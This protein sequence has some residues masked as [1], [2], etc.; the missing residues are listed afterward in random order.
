MAQAGAAGQAHPHAHAGA[1]SA[2][3]TTAASPAAAATLARPAPPAARSGAHRALAGHLQVGRDRLQVERLADEA[4]Q[5][6]HQLGRVHRAAGHHLVGRRHGEAHLFLRAQQDHV[7]QCRLHRVADAAPALGGGFRQRVAAGIA[8]VHRFGVRRPQAL[9][10]PVR[11]VHRQVAREGAAQRLVGGDQRLQPL[12]DLPVLA[13]APALQRLHED[14]ADAH[15][16][17]RDE[18]QAQQ[19][20]EDGGPGTEV[21]GVAHDVGWLDAGRAGFTSPAGRCPRRPGAA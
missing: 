7:R 15:R 1:C 18:H 8:F 10:A 17:Q 21:E 14:Q 11:R 13:L 12:V 19:G 4:P 16:H 6:G 9:R 20:G 5:R 2:T 3:T